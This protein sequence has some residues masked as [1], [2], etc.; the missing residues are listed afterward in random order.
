MT[1]T[2][3]CV[4]FFLASGKQVAYVDLTGPPKTPPE[5]V[6][7]SRVLVRTS[8]YGRTTP[9]PRT[10]PVTVKIGQIVSASGSKA[11]NDAVDVVLT[12]TSKSDISLPV[13]DDPNAALASHLADRRELVFSIVVEGAEARDYIGLGVAAGSA[14]YPDSIALLAPGDSVTY[15]VR[16]DRALAGRFL[17]STPELKIS[18]RVF[19]ERVFLDDDGIDTYA[20][21]GDIL[22]SEN[23]VSWSEK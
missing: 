18:V 11:A 17:L 7:N 9:D 23:S 19:Q 5:P 16:I 10:L 14:G 2:L 8:V 15:K 22:K 20:Q 13:G 4:A 21:W 12:N 6:S 3:V 1:K